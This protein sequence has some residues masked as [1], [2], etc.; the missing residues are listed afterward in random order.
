MKPFQLLDPR[1]GRGQKEQLQSREVPRLLHSHRE[2]VEDYTLSDSLRDAVNTALAL[3]AP[4]LLTGDPGTGKTQ[5][6]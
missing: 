5:L 3:G 2:G 4:L 6:A 1:Q